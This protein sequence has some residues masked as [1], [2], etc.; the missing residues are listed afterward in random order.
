M[1][2]SEYDL[3]ELQGVATGGESGF[4]FGANGHD[5]DRPR[6]EAALSDSQHRELLMLEAMSSDDLSKPYLERLPESY[7]AELVVFEWLEFLLTNA[8]FRRSLD[9]LRYYRSIGWLTPDVED[10]LGEYLRSFEEPAPDETPGLDRSDHVLSLVYIARL[11]AVDD[12][13]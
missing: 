4:A 7:A 11:A 5:A 1:N 12:P 8:G 3:A 2:P 6:A 13:R 9:A 10:E